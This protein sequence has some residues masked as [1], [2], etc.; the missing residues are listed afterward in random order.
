MITVIGMGIEKGDITQKGKQALKNASKR[1]SRTRLYV[2]TENLGKKYSTVATSYDELDSMIVGEILASEKAGENVVYCA[3]GD[4]YTDSIVKLLQRSTDVNIIAG[5]S[6]YRG[7][8]AGSSLY[9]LSAY[10]ID[11]NSLFDSSIDLLIYGIDDEFI[12][13]E[14]KPSLALAYGDEHDCVIST[15]K[16]S[17]TVKIYEIDRLKDYKGATL[18][19]AGER[20]FIKKNRFT[21]A[22]LV[23]VMTRLTAPDGCPWDKAQTHESI[24]I[25]MI[26]EAYESV[27]AIDK[28]DVDNM[29]EEF[30]DVLLQV[31]F[32]CDMSRR[33]GEFTFSDVVSDLTQKLVGRHTHIFGENK[34]TDEESALGFWEQAKAK[35]KHYSTLSEQLDRLPDTFPS[36]MLAQ[37]AVKKTVKKGVVITYDAVKDK[38]IKLINAGVT[39]E[40]SGDALML[41][42]ALVTLVGADGEVELNK[43]VKQF[44]DKIKLAEEKDA[45]V[46]A[47]ELL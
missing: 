39:V 46:G 16:G 42:L 1:F 30:G 12:A 38:L 44:I 45:L 25:N 21:F 4:G 26:E 23:A 8:T 27:D 5:V 33:Q 13:G 37:K 17:Q 32:H 43:A 36:T 11:E 2:K 34:A 35:E 22:D 18:F 14:I 9:Y 6:D 28:G 24:R 40:N 10:D 3:L 19:I 41:S 15:Q 20:D 31:I 7:K 29:R 47:D